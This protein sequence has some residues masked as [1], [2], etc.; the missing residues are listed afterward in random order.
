MKR[1]NI[2]NMIAALADTPKIKYKS[3]VNSGTKGG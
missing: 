1:K 3:D 2:L